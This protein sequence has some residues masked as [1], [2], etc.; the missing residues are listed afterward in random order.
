MNKLQALPLIAFWIT[1]ISYAAEPELYINDSEA[2][3][4]EAAREIIRKDPNVALITI[5]SEGQPRA[6]TVVARPPEE[7]MTIWIA[8]RP[9]TR[10]VAQIGHNRKVT[11]YFSVDS[12]SSYVTIMGTAT[13]HDDLSTKE[14]KKWRSEERR[15]MLWPNYP[16]DYLLIKVQPKWMEVLGEGISAHPQTWRPQAGVFEVR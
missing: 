1:A 6:R 9:T 10:K 16:N 4:I 12:E 14:A 13:L 2:D 11:L 5:D 7:D 8:T 15:K 3:I